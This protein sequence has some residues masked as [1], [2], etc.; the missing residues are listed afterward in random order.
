MSAKFSEEIA[1]C[2]PE[3]EDTTFSNEFKKDEFES[4]LYENLE[5]AGFIDQDDYGDSYGAGPLEKYGS[6]LNDFVYDITQ[7]AEKPY[8]DAD[9]SCSVL[10]ADGKVEPYFKDAL[11]QQEREQSAPDKHKSRGR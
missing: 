11:K 9:G 4:K 5:E 8:T 1:A 3:I 2:I 7:T 10:K 6:Y